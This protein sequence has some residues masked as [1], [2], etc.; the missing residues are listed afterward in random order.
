MRIRSHHQADAKKLILLHLKQR[1]DTSNYF[2]NRERFDYVTIASQCRTG[3]NV[4]I[5]DASGLGN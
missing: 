2:T 5:N 4:L 1:A 3:G